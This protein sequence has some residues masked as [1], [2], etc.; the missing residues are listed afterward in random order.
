MPDTELFTKSVCE[1]RPFAISFYSDM[2]IKVM[3]RLYKPFGY[4]K[5]EEETFKHVH[6]P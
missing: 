4:I 1:H 3:I 6:S 5:K 2:K